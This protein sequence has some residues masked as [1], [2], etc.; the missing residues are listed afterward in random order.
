MKEKVNKEE[1]AVKLF[2][3]KAQQAAP[4]GSRLQDKQGDHTDNQV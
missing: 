2:N 3:P 4:S 1:T